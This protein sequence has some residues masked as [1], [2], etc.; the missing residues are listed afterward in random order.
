MA[1]AA[2]DTI[3]VHK[4][5]GHWRGRG[6]VSFLAPIQQGGSIRNRCQQASTNLVKPNPIHLTLGAVEFSQGLLGA[7]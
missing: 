4:P 5:L 1:V 2:A 6:L 7:V 3:A